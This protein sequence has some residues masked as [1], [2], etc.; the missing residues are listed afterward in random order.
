MECLLG[1][2]TTLSTFPWLASAVNCERVTFFSLFEC[3]ISVWLATHTRRTI[4]T[5][6]NSAERKNRFTGPLS[7]QGTSEY[8]PHHSPDWVYKSESGSRCSSNT[9]T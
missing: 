2:K 7:A 9:P 4:T 5:S 6:G 1:V 8:E 3:G